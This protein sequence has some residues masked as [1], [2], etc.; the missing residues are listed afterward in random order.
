[1]TARWATGAGT[2]EG[3][4]LVEP[5]EGGEPLCH[6]P[7]PALALSTGGWRGQAVHLAWEQD[8]RRWA[9]TLDEPRAVAA[10]L[11]A[12]PARFRAEVAHVRAARARRRRRARLG[13]AALLLL[14][15][16]P[17]LG[18]GALWG[19]RGEV[20]DAVVRR[21]PAAADR[22]L[23]DLA[24]AQVRA[25][26]GLVADGPAADAVRR[27][28]ERL[29]AATPPHPFRFRFLVRRDPTVNAFA[30]PGG[31]VVVHTGLLADARS[32]D[33]LAGVLAHEVIHV[34]ERHSLRQLL[35]ELGLV[36]AVGLLLGGDGLAGAAGALARDLG[37]LHFGREQERAADRGAVDL[38]ARARLP[39]GGLPAFFERLAAAGPAV[40][41]LLASHPPSAERAAAL[42]AAIQRRGPWPVEPLEVDWA[43]VRRGAGG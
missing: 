34:L 35:A 17:L 23:G 38:L 10:L 19:F 31:L 1:V 14:G 5:E 42:A 20:L 29:V 12:L 18:A 2:D 8:G 16:L 7:A 37:A 4:L 40:P 30:A 21:L 13:V 27:A 24:E 28:G 26:G 43:A 33:E 11:A 25:A 41:P 22:R 36:T 32:A 39:A 6:V 3:A 15:F 9:V